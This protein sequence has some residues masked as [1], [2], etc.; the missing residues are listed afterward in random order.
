MALECTRTRWNREAAANALNAWK[1]SGLSL[2]A[3]AKRESI[4]YP[5]LLRWKNLLAAEE[6]A[7]FLPVVLSGVSQVPS[8]PAGVTVTARLNDGT[9]I[10]VRG[11]DPRELCLAMLRALRKAGAR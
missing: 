7:P 2:Y 1:A 4:A 3:F 6:P 10:S 9:R 5:K 11:P 8:V